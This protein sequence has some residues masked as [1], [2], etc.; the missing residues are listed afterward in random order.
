MSGWFCRSDVEEKLLAARDIIVAR[1]CTKVLEEIKFTCST[2]IADNKV[3]SEGF[4]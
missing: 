3:F 2:G 1:F 4:K